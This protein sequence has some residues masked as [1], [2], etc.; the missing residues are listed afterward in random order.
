MRK[1]EISEM[2][3]TQGG[4]S[5]KC[6]NAGNWFS[7]AGL[8]FT[9]VALVAVGPVGIIAGTWAGLSTATGGLIGAGDLI[10]GC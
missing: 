3:F 7:V 4:A 2:G 10:A 5:W 9:A 8:A 1:L 6:T